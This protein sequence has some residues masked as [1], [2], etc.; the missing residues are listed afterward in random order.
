METFFEWRNGSKVRE[1]LAGSDERSQWRPICV[2]QRLF[3]HQEGNGYVV[4]QFRASTRP[5]G[6]PVHRLLSPEAQPTR[7]EVFGA[8][9][10]VFPHPV[11]EHQRG[12]E[13]RDF[14]KGIQQFSSETAQQ[15]QREE[16]PGR[17]QHTQSALRSSNNVEAKD[18]RRLGLAPR[19]PDKLDLTRF[20]GNKF[21][22]ASVKEAHRS[23]APKARNELKPAL[24]TGPQ[25][26]YIADREFDSP[27][28]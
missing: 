23:S 11:A 26:M 8:I 27:G 25:K 22:S 4:C 17:T 15:H 14:K 5:Q 9:Q 12:G 13:R 6:Q 20:S 7:D 2:Q 24:L 21:R 16:G 18:I 28:L 10:L 19:G 3:Q 1:L